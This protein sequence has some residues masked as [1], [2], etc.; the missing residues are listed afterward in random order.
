MDGSNQ[1]EEPAASEAIMIED[2][3]TIS[4]KRSQKLQA[5]ASA[6]KDKHLGKEERQA[7]KLLENAS[8]AM[9]NLKQGK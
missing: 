4:R 9:L 5:K 7:K 2:Q 6:K 8:V 1:S 3:R